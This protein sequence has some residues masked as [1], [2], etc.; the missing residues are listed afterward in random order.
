MQVE[1]EGKDRYSKRRD[2][3]CVLS[4]TEPNIHT[5]PEGGHNL[6]NKHTSVMCSGDLNQVRDWLI[7][8]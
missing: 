5:E 7:D 1:S 3:L 2:S 6:S 8:W 4:N